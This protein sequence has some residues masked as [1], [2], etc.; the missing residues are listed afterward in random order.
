MTVYRNVG[1]SLVAE[2]TITRPMLSV[3]IRF[4]SIYT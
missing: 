1:Q 4:K 2:S 3:P